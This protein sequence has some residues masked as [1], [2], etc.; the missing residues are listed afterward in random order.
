M[1]RFIILIFAVFIVFPAFSQNPDYPQS[2]TIKKLFLDFQSQNGGELTSF[3]D[4]LHGFEFGVSTRLTDKLRF[5]VPGKFGVVQDSID[6]TYRTILGADAM[7]QYYFYNP[8]ANFVPYVTAGVGIVQEYKGDKDIMVPLGAGINFRVSDRAYINVQSEY[9]LSMDL[10][11]P[12][13]YHGLGIVYMIGNKMDHEPVVKDVIR[14]SDGD[15]VRDDID[16]CPQVKGPMEL[17]GCPDS[18]HDGVADY[19]D[20]CPDTKGLAELHGCPDSDGDGVP[21]NEDECPNVKGLKINKGCPEKDQMM[22]RDKDGIQDKE[23]K[24]PDEPGSVKTQGCPD[25]DGDGVADIDD[26]CPTL[27]GKLSTNGC[28]DRDNDGVSDNMDNCPDQPGLPI[29][30]GCPDTDGDG[31]D[32]FTD[33]CP[34][35]PGPVENKGCPKISAKDQKTLDIAM[36]A[37]QFDSGKATL[38][39]ESYK[40]LNQVADIMRRYPDYN[41]I[42]SG[43]TDNTGSALKNQKLSEN[44]AKAC[45]EYLLAQGIDGKRMTYVGYGESRPIANNNTLRGRALNRRVEFTLVPAK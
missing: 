43:H 18:D 27:P 39:A 12:A 37:V 4:Y 16:L 32:D 36:R 44:R 3:K 11:K 25:T 21:D 17:Q 45:Y 42:I 2:I 10:D 14:D 22:D 41:L 40:I 24:C 29:Y 30:K 6:N 38:K 23:D 26:K 20:A 31:L 19:K 5:Y 8:K 13:L 15:G 34:T 7:L 9:R 28:P 33:K 1:K 35:M